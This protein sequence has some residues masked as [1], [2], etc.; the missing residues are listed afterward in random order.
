ML[1]QLLRPLVRCTFFGDLYRDYLDLEDRVMNLEAYCEWLYSG[2]RTSTPHFPKE[3][4]VRQMA[5]K[6]DIKIFVETGTFQGGDG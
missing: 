6:Y 1:K 5:A 4:L 3:M 2:K